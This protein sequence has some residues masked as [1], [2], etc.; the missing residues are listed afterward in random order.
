MLLLSVQFFCKTEAALNN[1]SQLII[2][3]VYIIYLGISLKKIDQIF[4][5]KIDHIIKRYT[6]QRNR[7]TIFMEGTTQCWKDARLGI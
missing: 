7:Y 5:R 6:A 3:S 2:K 4:T 1:K